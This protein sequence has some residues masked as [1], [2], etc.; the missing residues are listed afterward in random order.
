MKINEVFSQQPDIARV[1]A[2]ADFLTGRAEDRSA[3]QK[4]STGAFLNLAKD[5]GVNL[6]LDQLK[7]ISQQPPLSDVIR[8]VE[9]DN[10]IFKTVD[11]TDNEEPNTT[12]DTEKAKSIVD[13]M[14][15]RANKKKGL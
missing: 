11:N 6:T 4:I 14:A 12:L 1:T 13:K 15:K 10:V 2:L 7:N 8:N 3:P 9:N 5:M